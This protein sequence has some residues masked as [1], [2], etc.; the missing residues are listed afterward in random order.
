MSAADG[1][2]AS[3]E[4]EPAVGSTPTRGRGLGALRH[5]NFALLWGG[6]IV[7]NTG[8]W[9]ATVGQGW[10]VL[11]LTDRPLYLGLVA[12]AFALPMTFL[13]PI[14]GAI[15]DRVDKLALMRVT[16]TLQMTGVLL[17]AALTLT[18]VVRVWHIIALAFV[19]AL[20]LSVDNP[21]RQALLPTL[22]GRE[23]L[24]SAISLNSVVYTGAALFGPAIGGLLLGYVG[25]GGLFL[26]D[27]ISYGAV[28]L[29]TLLIRGVDTRPRKGAGGL[30]ED[31][32]EGFRF[33][34]SSRLLL[35]LVAVSALSGLLGRSYP[36]LLPVFARDVWRVGE[37][38]YGLLLSA[39]GAGALLGAFGLAAIGE[40]RRKGRLLLLSMLAF[41]VVLLLF[42]YSPTYWPAVGLLLLAGILSSLLGASLATLIQLNAPGALRGRAMSLYTITVIG[43]PSLGSMATASVAEWIGARNAVGIAAGVLAVLSIWLLLRGR[44]LREAG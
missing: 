43:I 36:S 38:G 37:R 6:F 8:S 20:L 41:G 16:Q 1:R 9:M 7:S 23:D 31:V 28:L 14:G 2:Q 15:S 25:S 13:P 42:A 32:T 11:Q 22:V 39:P 26:I 30:L 35:L 33:V 10:L 17:L 44:T 27:G 4:A 24:M 18:G 5:R 19:G 40:V 34:A 12:L 29:A 3:T 21:N